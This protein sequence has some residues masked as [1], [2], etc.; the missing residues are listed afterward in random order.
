MSL[1][2]IALVQA[3]RDSTRLPEKVALPLA[4]EPLLQRVVERARR[5]TLI[6]KVVVICPHDD[7]GWISGLLSGDRCVYAPDVPDDDLVARHLAAAE[8]FNADIIC[9]IPSDNPCVEPGYID[10]AVR[11]YRAYP[12]PFYSNTTVGLQGR[13]IDGLGAEVLSASRLRWLDLNTATLSAYREHP[14]RLFY[15]QAERHP[16]WFGFPVS[17]PTLRLDVNTQADYEFIK[18]I[19]EHVYPTT[20]D[21]TIADVLAYLATKVHVA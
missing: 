10:E 14:H 3:R 13:W 6:Q 8:A 7:L 17:A 18:Y 5:A 21:F 2:I 19:Y 4:G 20:P 15:E 16:E 9:R 1:N 11:T 12:L